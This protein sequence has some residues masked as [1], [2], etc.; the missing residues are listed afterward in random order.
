MEGTNIMETKG[1]KPFYN[2][3]PG[4][5]ILD[6]LTPLAFSLLLCFKEHVQENGVIY[7]A[8]GKNCLESSDLH[9]TTEFCQPSLKNKNEE[10]LFC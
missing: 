4:D 1:L 2:V 8:G 7:Q 5:F 3:G 10:H 6:F 9:N